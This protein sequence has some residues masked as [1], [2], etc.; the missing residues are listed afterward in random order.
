MAM[1]QPLFAN[2]QENLL[3]WSDWMGVV[4]WDRMST[5]GSRGQ[6]VSTGGTALWFDLEASQEE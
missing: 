2:G 5:H 1:G 6:E 3:K 4:L